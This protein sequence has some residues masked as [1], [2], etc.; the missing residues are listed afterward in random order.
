MA[1]VLKCEI[2]AS[3]TIYHCPTRVHPVQIGYTYVININ[4]I[5]KIF[6]ETR[7]M[8][9]S[10]PKLPHKSLFLPE[11]FLHVSFGHS[12][13]PPFPNMVWVYYAKGKGVFFNVLLKP[14]CN[15]SRAII[16]YRTEHDTT[17]KHFHFRPANCAQMVKSGLEEDIA[18]PKD[19]G[20]IFI[21]GDCFFKFSRERKQI[22]IDIST[23]YGKIDKC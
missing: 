4:A 1:G 21:H 22:E 19:G 9:L 8:R 3:K 6:R 10:E 17:P 20:K 14:N 13:A 2:S 12:H 11:M 16:L 23:L 7:P 18:L 5:K 15:F